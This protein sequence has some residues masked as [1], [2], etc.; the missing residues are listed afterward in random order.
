M[1]KYF[2][3]FDI[4]NTPSRGEKL[5]T[6]EDFIRCMKSFVCDLSIRKM[7]LVSFF[8]TDGVLFEIFTGINDEKKLI[9]TVEDFNPHSG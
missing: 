7:G 2:I 1:S 6:I 3:H 9:Y 5:Y 8:F 4:Q